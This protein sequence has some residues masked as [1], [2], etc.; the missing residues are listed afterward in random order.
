MSVPHLAKTPIVLYAFFVPTY[1]NA[2][3]T[4]MERREDGLSTR[5]TGAIEGLDHFERAPPE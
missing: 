5:F 2:D 3:D 1:R 4:A